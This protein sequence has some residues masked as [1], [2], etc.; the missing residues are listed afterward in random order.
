MLS[1]IFSYS[2]RTS[3]CILANIDNSTRGGK[4]RPVSIW[5][6][7]SRFGAV[8]MVSMVIFCLISIIF[9]SDCVNCCSHL[10][11][12]HFVRWLFCCGDVIRFTTIMDI[13]NPSDINSVLLS[14]I[15]VGILTIVYSTHDT[16]QTI[17][18]QRNALSTYLITI[19]SKYYDYIKSNITE[20]TRILFTN[21][22]ISRSGEKNGV[23]TVR[24]RISRSGDIVIISMAVNCIIGVFTTSIMMNPS[25]YKNFYHFGTWVI[26][27]SI[28]ILKT[29]VNTQDL[30]VIIYLV[31]LTFIVTICS[32]VIGLLCVSASDGDVYGI[33]NAIGLFKKYLLSFFLVSSIMATSNIFTHCDIS[34]RGGKNR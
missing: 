32:F 3:S 29:I 10:Y 16:F 2:I 19:L 11:L 14:C 20:N 34:T 9:A 33:I 23:S 5:G 21:I 28:S 31:Y 6:R 15:I 18:R 13:W 22:G 1:F 12:Y 7:I 4:N 17:F 26:N 27:T 24:R 30:N 25:Y 8:G